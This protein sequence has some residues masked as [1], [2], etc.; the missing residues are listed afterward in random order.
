MEVNDFINPEKVE[1]FTGTMLGFNRIL[2]GSIYY[3][4]MSKVPQ[5]DIKNWDPV[6][7][8]EVIKKFSIAIGYKCYVTP[9]VENV[10]GVGNQCN[11]TGND[12]I[13]LGWAGHNVTTLRGYY[14]RAD[15]RD[16]DDVAALQFQGLPFILALNPVKYRP[17]FRER[18]LDETHPFP[19]P[20]VEPSPP[21]QS[22]YEFTD[23]AG[24]VNFDQ[25]GWDKALLEFNTKKAAYDTYVAEVLAVRQA[26][27]DAYPTLDKVGTK[28]SDYRYGF[29]AKQVKT[30][31]ENTFGD[32][33]PHLFHK[34]ANGYDVDYLDYEQL[35][36]PMVLALQQ[37]YAHITL[38]R[39]TINNVMTKQNGIIDA[40]NAMKTM[41][42]TDLGLDVSTITI[43]DVWADSDKLIG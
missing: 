35:I 4:D 10:V 5:F 33:K 25:S 3:P 42:E 13:H 40:L 15:E 12:S 17:I 2:A 43:P 34:D 16:M 1:G 8:P 9:D 24:V 23:D 39:S 7:T 26:R 19:F 11:P 22:D 32:F 30:A 18:Y 37:E 29:I 6:F 20:V 31:G 41:M 21:K 28:E 36:A 14:R 38:H 27:K